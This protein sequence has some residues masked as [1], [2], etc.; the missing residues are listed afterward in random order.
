MNV[1]VVA[2]HADDETLGVG[3]TIAK[4]SRAGDNVTVAVLTGHGRERPHP[5]WPADAWDQVRAEC[6]QAAEVMGVQELIFEEVP[7][8]LAA[9]EPIYAV[10]SLVGKIV[11]EVEP[12]ILYVPFPFDV[13]RDHRTFFHSLSVAWRPTSSVGRSIH[14]IYCY[15]TQSETHWNIPYVEAGFLPTH[16]VDISETLQIKQEAMAC[17]QSQMHEFPATRSI[18]ALDALARWRGSLVGVIAAE[19][20]VTVRSIA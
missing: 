15:E 13:H 6:R 16:F 19:A 4:H 18:E 8:L 17:Y 12:E 5:V 20:F 9:E 14:S 10:N 3:G 7:A 2:P 11:Q 1:L